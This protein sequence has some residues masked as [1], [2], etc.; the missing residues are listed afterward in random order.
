MDAWKSSKILATLII[1][2]IGITLWIGY[3]L[4]S[5]Y[6]GPRWF[7]SREA[8]ASTKPPSLYQNV[9]C[10]VKTAVNTSK[11]LPEFIELVPGTLVYS[12]FYDNT[13]REAP[14][15][16]IM[17]IS[18]TFRP[19][20]IFCHSLC[21]RTKTEPASYKLIREHKKRRHA[22]FIAT[23][24]APRG[25]GRTPGFLDIH[26]EFEGQ[27]TKITRVQV[28]S[29]A[30][31]NRPH[32]LTICVP[33]I[34]KG[35]GPTRN[36]IVEFIEMNS[37]LGADHF[38]FYDVAIPSDVKEVLRHY[39][40]K[41][42]ASVLTWVMPAYML[43]FYSIHY[44]GQ[45]LSIQDCLYRARGTSRFVAFH[46][47][48]EFIVPT[49]EETNP[50]LLQR[51]HKQDISGYRIRSVVF[52]TQL[53]KDDDST[54]LITQK[55]FKRTASYFDTRSKCVVDPQRVSVMGI[56]DIDSPSE[57]RFKKDW[58]ITEATVY[59]YRQCAKYEDLENACKSLIF[60]NRMKLYRDLLKKKVAKV[61]ALV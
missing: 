61:L 48:D 33:P 47:L 23:C 25:I 16:R 27:V 21:E 53:G 56:H 12:A 46:D 41:G 44:H 24:T 29:T 28:Q 54:E 20:P 58:I 10:I 2:I 1:A 59:H 22:A 36:E 50:E 5:Y 40:S 38:V 17:I 51:I 30:A 7:L 32:N 3:Y 14:Y 45:M 6:K 57:A 9:N 43:D 49:Q 37:I 42:V 11:K 52:P 4:S 18:E 35:D 13:N 26:A 34:Y 8:T 31:Q 19:V 39:E 55:Y 15:F 60:E